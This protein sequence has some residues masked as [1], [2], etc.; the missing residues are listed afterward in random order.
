MFYILLKWT[1]YVWW[2]FFYF[3]NQL[4]FSRYRPGV[5]QT[6]GRGIALLF[7]DRSTRRGWVVSSTPWPHFT[8]GKD[9]VPILQ[10]VGWSPGPVW[11]GGKSRPHRDSIP[12]RP[13]R[14]YNMGSNGKLIFV[15]L[16]FGLQAVLKEQMKVV[17]WGITV[18]HVFVVSY[19]GCDVFYIL[20]L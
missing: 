17:N 13:A 3:W 10:E 11:T 12:D 1:S 20:L 7:H 8:P 4:K 16:V 18:F 14:S 9:P 2:E 19:A 15:L 5:A 6:V